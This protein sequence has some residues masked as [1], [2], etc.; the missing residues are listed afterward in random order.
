MGLLIVR[1]HLQVGSVMALSWKNT[2]MRKM[3][4][5]VPLVHRSVRKNALLLSWGVHPQPSE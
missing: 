3:L 2:V 5:T 1:N 4:A